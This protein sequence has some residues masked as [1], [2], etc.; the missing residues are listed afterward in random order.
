MGGRTSHHGALVHANEIMPVEF[1]NALDRDYLMVEQ[2]L[3]THA[4]IV[5]ENQS[6]A[7]R[8]CRSKQ[9]RRARDVPIFSYLLANRAPPFESEGRPMLDP[10]RRRSG[11][12]QATGSAV[13]HGAFASHARIIDLAM[14]GLRLQ[15]DDA[16]TLPEG[17]ARVALDVRLD[18]L[19][20]WLHLIGS[21][22]RVDAR[23]AGARLVIELHVV[24]ADFEDLVQDELLSALECA[25]RPR[26]LVVDGARGRRELVAA[27]FR[28]AGCHVIEVSSPLEAIAE[29]DQSRLHLWAVV[30]ADT[31]RASQANELRKFVAETYP[32]VRLIDI[33]RRVRGHG[34][35]R[36]SVDG[37]PDLAVQIHDFVATRE[38]VGTQ[39]TLSN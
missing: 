17:G 23:G 33:G 29:I 7:S 39:S 9:R 12:V 8:T 11:R 32:Y 1:S 25:Q 5:G 26:I 22:V 34:T 38:S 24:P 19:G 28:A 20:R 36:L 10:E 31:K 6:R 16:A 37:I 18:G 14:G 27:A 15:V 35:T 30:I 2:S 4:S 13:I 3:E 21:I